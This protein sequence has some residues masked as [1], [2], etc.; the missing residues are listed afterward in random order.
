MKEGG[1]KTGPAIFL[2]TLIIVLIY[3]WWLLFY[4]H[5]VKAV[6]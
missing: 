5:G 2:A 6:H 1:R 3:F 4:S